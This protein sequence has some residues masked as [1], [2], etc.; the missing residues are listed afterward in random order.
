[1]LAYVSLALGVFPVA[2]V[3]LFILDDS[4]R[5]PI[6]VV[7]IP[8]VLT[9]WCF[10]TRPFRSKPTASCPCCGGLAV[11]EHLDER[12]YFSCPGCNLREDTTLRVNEDP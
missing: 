9:L 3:L 10:F 5:V 2:I 4:I 7:V 8:D 11:I 6:G 12:W 1:M